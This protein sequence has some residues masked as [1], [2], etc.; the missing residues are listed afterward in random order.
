MSSFFVRANFFPQRH[1]FSFVSESNSERNTLYLLILTVM[2][3]IQLCKWTHIPGHLNFIRKASGGDTHNDLLSKTLQ[4]FSLNSDLFLTGVV[5]C[6]P[7][8]Q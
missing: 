6:V 2:I 3:A 8:V 1:W 4:V 5:T 7:L